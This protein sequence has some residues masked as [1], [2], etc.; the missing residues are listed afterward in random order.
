MNNNISYIE[1]IN[2]AMELAGLKADE[3]RNFEAKLEKGF[4]YVTFRTDFQK[5]ECYV[6]CSTGE[7][8]G[9][10]FEPSID[11]DYD[12]EKYVLNDFRQDKSLPAA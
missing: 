3:C 4:Y 8:P 6:D 5:Y 11:I 7:V 10:N 2:A 9:L 12:D 1:A